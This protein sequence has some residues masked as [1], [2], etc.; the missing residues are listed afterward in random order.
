[1]TSPPHLSAESFA[2]A[3]RLKTPVWVFD[4][5]NLVMCWANAAG[6]SIWGAGDLEE[7]RSRDFAT[8]ISVS[9]RARLRNYLARFKAGETVLETWTLYPNGKPVPMRCVCSG[10]PLQNGQ[11]MLVEAQPVTEPDLQALRAQEA[12]RHTPTLMSAFDSQGNLLTRNPSA[13]TMLSYCSNTQLR[14]Q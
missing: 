7:L 11:G 5:E 1:M 6:V 9:A 3:D 8:E 10:F 2:V 4:I 14:A 13:M 12:L